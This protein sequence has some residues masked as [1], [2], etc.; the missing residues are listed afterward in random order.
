[1][2][3]SDRAKHRAEHGAVWPYDE[4]TGVEVDG[5]HVYSA[6]VPT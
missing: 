5:V 1:M 3:G 2:Q 6:E 4:Q